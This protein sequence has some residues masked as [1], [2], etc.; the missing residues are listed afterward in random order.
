MVPTWR[1]IVPA[2]VLIG[3]PMGLVMLQPDLG[4]ALAIGF[5]GACTMFLAGLPLRWFMMGGGAAAVAAPMAFF[6]LLHD[7]QRKRVFTFL[8]PESDPLG[9]G[10]HITQSKIA[11]GSGGIAGKGFGK[12]SQSHL[13]LP[14]RTAHRLRLRHHGRGMGPARRAVRADRLLPHSAL[15]LEGR[16]GAPRTG[17]P[18][19][20]RAAWSRRYSSTLRST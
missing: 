3:M 16:D 4:T 1:S 5:G 9:T 8:D 2:G 18:G 11:I 10:Y 12:G 17:S 6:T 7:Y 15:G 13:E 20:W 19:C 14:A